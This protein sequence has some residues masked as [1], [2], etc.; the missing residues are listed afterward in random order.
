MFCIVGSVQ[1]IKHTHDKTIKENVS[2][3]L[4]LQ[5]K[6]N[7]PVP[8]LS[9]LDNCYILLFKVAGSECLSYG[10]PICNF[11]HTLTQNKRKH[12]LTLYYLS[13]KAVSDCFPFALYFIL[14][15]KGGRYIMLCINLQGH[16]KHKRCQKRSL[17]A[18]FPSNQVSILAQCLQ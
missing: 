13:E 3:F 14:V 5:K 10:I 7:P 4:S 16:H 18:I 2:I 1:S 15:T 6:K 8:F 11:K 9:Y 17:K 12:R